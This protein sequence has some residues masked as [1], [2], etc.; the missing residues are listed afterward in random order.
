VRV[1]MYGGTLAT[2]R[3]RDGGFEVVADIPYAPSEESA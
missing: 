2:G 1:T 3:G